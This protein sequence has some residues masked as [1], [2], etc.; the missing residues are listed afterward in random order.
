VGERRPLLANGSIVGSYEPLFKYWERVKEKGGE[1]LI[2]GREE[3]ELIER[4]VRE[5]GRVSLLQLKNELVQ[6]FLPRVD[7]DAAREAFGSLGVQLD[8]S[9]AR[10]MIAEIF[11]GWAL[12]AARMLGIVEFKGWLPR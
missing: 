5:E 2:I 12:E 9:E 8:A 4:R 7:P 3:L 1:E 10:R 6:R 11:A